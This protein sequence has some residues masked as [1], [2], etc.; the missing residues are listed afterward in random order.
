MCKIQYN[1]KIK[2]F[3]RQRFH[4]AGNALHAFQPFRDGVQINSEFHADRCCKH[5]VKN[6][7]KP[8]NGNIDLLVS[9]RRQHFKFDVARTDFNVGGANIG[10]FAANAVCDAWDIDTA[11]QL[12]TVAVIGIHNGKFAACEH[13][14][15]CRKIIFKSF[16]IIKMILRKVR[17]SAYEILDSVNP[18]LIQCVRT[19]FHHDKLNTLVAHKPEHTLKLNA[20]RCGAVGGDDSVADKVSNRADQSDFIARLFGDRFYHVCCCRF[21]VRAGDA[22]DRDSVKRMTVKLNC[23]FGHCMT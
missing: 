21:S 10:F 19:D 13:N 7:E 4:P 16:V 5:C 22:D 2:A 18:V 23:K 11:K 17:E 20:F 9:V 15:F 6:I 1:G 14:F 3:R 12:R 8:G